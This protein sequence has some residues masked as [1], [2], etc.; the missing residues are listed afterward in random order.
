MDKLPTSTGWGSPDVWTIHGIIQIGI[1]GSQEDGGFDPQIRSLRPDAWNELGKA[2]R[3][4]GVMLLQGSFKWDPYC[5]GKSNN[6][7]TCYM[8]HSFWGT[9]TLLSCCL[10]FLYGGEYF[11]GGHCV[12][13]ALSQDV[14]CLEIVSNRIH[15]TGVSTYIY[16]KHQPNEGNYT[17]ITMHGSYG[18]LFPNFKMIGKHVSWH[19][20]RRGG[21]Q[22]DDY[23]NATVLGNWMIKW[24]RW[25]NCL[26]NHP[27]AEKRIVPNVLEHWK[28]T[29]WRWCL[30]YMLAKQW[31]RYHGLIFE[32]WGRWFFQKL[33]YIF[34]T[35]PP[36]RM[37]LW[38]V[39][40]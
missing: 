15:V 40:F 30:Y 6:T 16:Q 22:D 10:L 33:H 20:T 35:Y 5:G 29:W 11:N 26:R 14:E 2:W 27:A 36:T 38:Q 19:L 37:Q 8:I 23:G 21:H 28:T 4:H 3:N 9:V 17:M 18:F 1:P 13:F 24:G 31:K 39:K 34:W 25:I 7:N 32:P 12:S